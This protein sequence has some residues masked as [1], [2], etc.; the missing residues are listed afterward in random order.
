MGH[1]PL[2][3][4]DNMDIIAVEIRAAEGGQDA[5]LLAQDMAAMYEKF[6]SRRCL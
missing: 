5:K 3:Q 6:C 2:T 4:G 1:V